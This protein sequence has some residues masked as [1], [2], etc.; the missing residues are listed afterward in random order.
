MNEDNIEYLVMK[1]RICSYLYFDERLMKK[2][3]VF[4]N[5]NIKFPNLKILLIFL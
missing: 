3:I 5:E 4:W 2:I 1:I